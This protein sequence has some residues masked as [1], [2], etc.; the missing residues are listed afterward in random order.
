MKLF[1]AY[2]KQRGR[3]L[4]ALVLF[5]LIFVVSFA[6]Y[7][8]PVAAVLYPAGICL[9]VAMAF[10][11]YDFQKVCR[12]HRRLKE[13]Q[14]NL[15][16]LI[17][18]FPAAAGIEEA[19]YQRII[20]LLYRHQTELEALREE[21]VRDMTDYYTVWAHQIKTPISSMR[22]HLQ[23]EDTSL[24]RQLMNDLNRIEQYVEMVLV[25]LRLD[26]ESSD[27]VI[28]EYDLDA[29]VKA[30]V[31]KF[32]GEFIGRRLKLEYEPLNTTVLTDEK[33]LSFVV[34]QVLSNALKYTREGKISI[35]LEEPKTLC[36]RDTGIGIAS[37]DLPRIFE[38]GYTGYNGRCDKRASGLGLYLCRR[39]CRNLNHRILA[40]SVPDQ[41]TEIR[42]D[43]SREELRVE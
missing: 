42:I 23:N 34:E 16:G 20:E 32:S 35:C 3:L 28:A 17:E 25:F 10:S 8:L 33:W 39:I 30:A 38:K 36:I 15:T 13:L 29:I 43:L 9:V 22:L 11:A 4:L 2:L 7:H 24:S 31:R 18:S 6:L 5:C 19:D 12:K 1:F 26:S 21:W 27:Y 37:E 40:S 41:G 14:K